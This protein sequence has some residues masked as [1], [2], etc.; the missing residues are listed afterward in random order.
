MNE[1]AKSYATLRLQLN[2]SKT[3]FVRFG[4]RCN[5]K[6]ITQDDISVC[7]GSSIALHF[8]VASDIGVLLDSELSIK[9]HVNKVAGTIYYKQSNY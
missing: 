4:T 1:H 9:Q 2:S 8:A 5:R 6:K 3:E 7:V